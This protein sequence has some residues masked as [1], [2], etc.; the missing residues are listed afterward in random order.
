MTEEPG[1]ITI[2]MINC[3]ESSDDNVKGGVPSH[4][5]S[6]SCHTVEVRSMLSSSSILTSVSLS[7]RKIIIAIAKASSLTTRCSLFCSS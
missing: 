3:W 4:G 6:T 2:T 7:H 5:E 1:D